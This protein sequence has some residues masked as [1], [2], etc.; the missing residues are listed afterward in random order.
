MEFKDYFSKHASEYAKYRP[1]YPPELFEYLA[2]ITEKHNIAWDSAAGNGQAAL[3][4][5]P[6][7]DQVIATDASGN[8]IKN[9]ALHPKIEYRVAPSEKSRIEPHSVNLVT[10]ATAIHWFKLEKFYEEVKRVLVPGGTLAIWNYGEANVNEP[11]DKVFNHFLYDIIGPYAAPEFWKGINQ[12]TQIDFPFDRIKTPQFIMKHLWNMT[13]Y[14]N[15][16]MTWSPT[17]RYIETNNANPVELII[18]DLKSAWGNES[19]RKEI[20]WKLMLKAARIG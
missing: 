16:M 13:D 7:F 20:S 2:S 10:V 4:L 1:V 14:T 12:E 15:F 3:G 5:V 17:Q 6:Y 9:A 19:D 18:D 8:Q 11:V